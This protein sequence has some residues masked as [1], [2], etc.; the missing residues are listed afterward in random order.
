MKDQAS[1][2]LCFLKYCLG[3]S[4]TIT[5]LHLLCLPLCSPYFLIKMDQMH[6]RVTPTAQTHLQDQALPQSKAQ[7]SGFPIPNT[8]RS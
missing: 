8:W 1:K 2:K 3:I 5:A 6:Q 4:I 7:R